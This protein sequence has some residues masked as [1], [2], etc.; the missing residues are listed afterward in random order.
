MLS[1]KQSKLRILASLAI[2][3]SLAAS[4]SCTG[5][6]QNPVLTTLTIGPSTL[7]LNQG[8]TQ[9]MFATGTYNDG[10]TKNLTSGVIWSS[11]EP[12]VAT[13]STSGVVTGVSVGNTSITGEFG[14]ITGT[15]ASVTVALAN[16]TAITIDPL[17]AT[18]PL[19]GGTSVPF[20][21]LATVSGSSTQVPVT[22]TV[23]WTISA[24]SGGGNS[25]DDFQINGQ[26]TSEITVT[27][28]S[29]AGLGEV[30]TL[31]AT[32]TSSTNTF[33]ENAKIT[34]TSN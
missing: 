14:T 25:V 1:C 17:T 7:N 26:G 21:A 27:T 29:T 16:V 30:A 20:T 22:S 4:T 31:T 2:A 13:V 28:Q 8:A 23:M 5:F 10:S 11:S 33:V 3:L 6:F 24:A 34:V 12:G 32:Y 19:D 18:V 15:P 9:Q